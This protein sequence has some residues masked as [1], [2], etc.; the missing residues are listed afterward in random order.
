MLPNVQWTPDGMGGVVGTRGNL[1]VWLAPEEGGWAVAVSH[2]TT[3]VTIAST[4]GASDERAVE[5]LRV[6]FPELS[7]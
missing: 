4:R 3:Q 6:H 2:A 7:A 1:M 5:W